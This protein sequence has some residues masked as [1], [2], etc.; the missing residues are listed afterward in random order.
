MSEKIDRLLSNQHIA[1]RG[2]WNNVFERYMGS[3]RLWRNIAILSLLTATVAVGTASWLAAQS[4]VIPYVVEVDKLGS[5]TGVGRAE[6]AE[7][8]DQRVIRAY[9]GRF[10]TDW[11]TVTVD[12]AAQRLGIARLDAMLPRP[13]ASLQYVRADLEARNPYELARRGTIHPEITNIL[14]VTDDTW[15]VEWY[16]TWRDLNG[17]VIKRE[18]FKAALVIS[19]K[20]PTTDEQ[21]LKNPLGV[22]I[23]DIKYTPIRSSR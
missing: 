16:E 8:A 21:V 5:V 18:G 11:R 7:P 10:V 13:S 23:D 17:E 4:K 2:E 12:G 6:R 15:Q 14:P 1:A 22:M 3:A 20:T 19:Q 9:L